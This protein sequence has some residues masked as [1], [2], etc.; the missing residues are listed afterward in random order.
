[1]FAGR[2]GVISFGLALTF[3]RASAAEEP[4]EDIIL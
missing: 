3:R 2:V 4:V 1:M